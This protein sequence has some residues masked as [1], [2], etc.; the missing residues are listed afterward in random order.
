MVRDSQKRNS[1][2]T[3]CSLLMLVPQ[4]KRQAEL[5]DKEERMVERAI[6]FE[7]ES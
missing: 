5:Y 3:G 4:R 2:G 6:L 7:E 1:V